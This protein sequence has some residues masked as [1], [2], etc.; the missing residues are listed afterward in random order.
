MAKGDL[1][2]DMF[3][4]LFGTNWFAKTEGTPDNMK[5]VETRDGQLRSYRTV[6][7]ETGTTLTVDLPGVDPKTVQLQVGGNKVVVT[8]KNGKKD[9]TQRYTLAGELDVA[10]ARATLK[11]GQLVIKIARLP[12]P[13]LKNVPIEIK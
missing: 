12:V 8:G 4:D 1:F 3:S 13:D 9:F 5:V 2:G 7:D 6:S 11:L 10:S